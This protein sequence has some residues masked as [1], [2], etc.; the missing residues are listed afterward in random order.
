[1]FNH[2]HFEQEKEAA[3]TDSG[4][5][6]I[7]SSA[8]SVSSRPCDDNRAVRISPTVLIVGLVTGDLLPRRLVEEAAGWPSTNPERGRMND[9]SGS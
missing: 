8:A 2:M 4:Q 9:D 3:E 7:T 5:P 6:P 1:M